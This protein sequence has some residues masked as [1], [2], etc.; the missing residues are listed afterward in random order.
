MGEA[1]PPVMRGLPPRF[2]PDC[3]AAMFAGIE[4]TDPLRA[5]LDRGGAPLDTEPETPRPGH[6]RSTAGGRPTR[7]PGL[8]VDSLAMAV[9]A[10]AAAAAQGVHAH[11]AGLRALPVAVHTLV[12]ISFVVPGL[13]GVI[14]TSRRPVG[15]RL[16]TTLAHHLRVVIVP[17]LAGAAASLMLWRVLEAPAHL[18]PAPLDTVLLTAVLGAVIVAVSRFAHDA[19][20]RRHG[21]RARRVVIVGSGVVAERMRTQLTSRRV[22]VVGFVDDDP[23]DASN[24]LGP[25]FALSEVSRASR[26]TMWSWPSRARAASA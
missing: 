22:Q 10:I 26:S 18:P 4:A 14:A 8:V 20:P 21:R 13:V 7:V 24:C 5:L 25:L 16:Q 15:C 6:R 9:A 17:L 11:D 23:K 19:P 2:P 12:R 1:A 3:D